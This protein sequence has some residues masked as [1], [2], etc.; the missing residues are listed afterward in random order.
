MSGMSREAY[1]RTRSRFLA[2]PSSSWIGL[3]AALPA[4]S[5]SA[6][7]MLLQR[8][9]SD[10]APT[11]IDYPAVHLLPEPLGL[12]RVFADEQVVQAVC[13]RM[14]AGRVDDRAH[15]FRG[16][17]DLADFVIPLV[18]VDAHDQVVLLPSPIAWSSTGWRRTIASTS[19]IFSAGPVPSPGL[20][21][22]H[23]IVYNPTPDGQLPGSL[24]DRSGRA[25]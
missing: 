16:R 24:H 19:V 13:D 5:H 20:S 7:S 21:T 8:V 6:I 11:D 18:G 14:R 2:P 9:Q 23:R 17:V 4:M 12:E 15:G 1:A 22:I 25:G 3:P 10:S